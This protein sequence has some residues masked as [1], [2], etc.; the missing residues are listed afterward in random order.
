MRLG[1]DRGERYAVTLVGES[2]RR[3]V[4]TSAGDGFTLDLKLNPGQILLVELTR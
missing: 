2:F 4:S 3:V 1:M